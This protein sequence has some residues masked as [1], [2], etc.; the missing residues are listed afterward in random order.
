MRTI[1]KR[2]YRNFLAVYNMIKAKGYSDD[3]AWKITDK[4]FS[5]FE[6]NPNGLPILTHVEMIV[7][8]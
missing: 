5:D 7:S 8:Q 4:I 2:T 3:E 6:M 1:K